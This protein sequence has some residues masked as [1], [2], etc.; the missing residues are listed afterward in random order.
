MIEIA[1]ILIIALSNLSI[2][3]FG[4][5]AMVIN[6]FV[7]IGLDMI[8]RDRIHEK[9]KNKNLFFVMF[10]LISAGGLL[11][12]IT[13]ESS[14]NI[15]VASC[16]A[17]VAS[18]SVNTVVYRVLIEKGWM[19]KSNA[20]NFTGSVVDSVIFPTLAFGTLMPGI[21]LMQVAA[22]FLGGLF[23]SYSFKKIGV[24]K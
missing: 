1:Y 12:F 21:I 19:V 4:P 8:L 6:S 17:F 14:L 5:E 15:A 10:S 11:S 13:S 16:V 2:S 18:M 23:W 20:S 24:A 7:L 3:Y 22:K 9:Y